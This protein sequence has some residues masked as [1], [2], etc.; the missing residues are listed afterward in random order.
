MNHLLTIILSIGTIYLFSPCVLYGQTPTREINIGKDQTYLN[1]PVTWSGDLTKMRIIQDGKVLDEVT[2]KLA[3]TEPDF[4]TFFDVT[5]YQGKTITLETEGVD[6]PKGL[7]M[8]YADAGF[9]GQDSVYDELL[10][11]RVHFSSRRGWINDPNGLI[12]YNNEYHLYY[13]HNPFGW[14]WG[15]MHWGHAVSKDLVHWK[16]LPDALYIPDHEDMAFSGTAVVDERNTSGFRKNGIDPLIAVYTRTGRGEYLALSY[17]NG[18][19]FDDYQG[20]PVLKHE[21]RDPKV[22]W[23]APGNHW[24]MVVYD[25][26]RT[27]EISLGELAMIPNFSIY[28]SSNLKEW[29]F[30]SYIPEFYECPELFELP[31]ENEPGVSKWVM[32]DAHGTYMVGD[33]DGKKFSIDQYYT[34]YDHGGSFYASQTYS[35]IPEKDGRRIQVGWGRVR[36]PGMPFNHCMTFPT[37]LS[38]KK[39]ANGYRL[40]PQP[41]K[42]ISALYSNSHSF[43]DKIIKEDSPFIAP[44]KGDVLHIIAEFEKGDAPSFGLDINGYKLMYNNLR[45]R[46][47]N[48]EGDANDEN[49]AQANITHYIDPG[50]DSFKIEVLVDKTII[51]VFVNDGALYYV[52]P[53]RSVSAKKNIAVL[54]TGDPDR[55]TILKKLEV[56]ELKAIWPEQL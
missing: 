55:K 13:Q 10:R 6:P 42:E 27:K 24:V 28:T 31:V 1:F 23:Y 51:E 7:D 8:V 53:Y 25:E 36:A 16:E 9:P 21:G 43:K 12:Y 3:D 11:P 47:I 4:W 54:S 22:F 52:I 30:Q 40:C 32:Y 39:T 33:F 34:P 5:P 48:A 35:N 49:A 29:T 15:N 45:G 41:V 44:V 19:T 50:N 14:N 2:L 37:Q 18:R 17:D 46:F 20:N 26:S 56:H 38:L